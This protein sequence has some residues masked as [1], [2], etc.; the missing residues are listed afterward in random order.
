[1]VFKVKRKRLGNA[2]LQVI[3][4]FEDIGNKNVVS[5]LKRHQIGE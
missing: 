4:S 5:F 3:L 1:M 2:L